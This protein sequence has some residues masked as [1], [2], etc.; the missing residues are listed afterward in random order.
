MRTLS[1]I[2]RRNVF[3]ESGEDLGRCYDVRGE[4]TRSR[5]RITGLV[6]GR[7]GKLEHL[8]IA[9]QASATPVRVRDSDVIPWDAILRFEADRIV[10]RDPWKAT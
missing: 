6:V 8:G 10:V 9:G 5:L 1:S 4:L 7:R 2:C 3:T